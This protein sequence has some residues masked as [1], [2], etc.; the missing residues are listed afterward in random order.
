M[1][2]PYSSSENTGSTAN[3]V[4]FDSSVEAE[5]GV[6]SK[7]QEL[8]GETAIHP[9]VSV[10][11]EAAASQHSWN[12]EERLL[13][14]LVN[15][16]PESALLKQQFCF[17]GGS[18]E[19]SRSAL[20]LWVQNNPSS[21][22]S[23]WSPSLPQAEVERSEPHSFRASSSFARC[24]PG[25]D[26]N[27][28]LEYRDVQMRLL[29]E[30]QNY[31]HGLIPETGLSPE[32]HEAMILCLLSFPV[33]EFMSIKDNE[34]NELKTKNTSDGA[35]I[36]MLSYTRKAL[37]HL[38][39][40]MGPQ[41]GLVAL[42]LETNNQRDVEITA[43]LSGEECFSWEVWRNDFTAR[44]EEARKSQGAKGVETGPLISSN[45]SI[46]RGIVHAEVIAFGT[47]QEM[48]VWSG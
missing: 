12:Q 16:E 36:A 9:G 2:Y 18:M 15:D 4:Q 10:D 27:G 37:V 28:L 11:R 17:L 46:T 44:L 5:K 32:S 30:I 38:S 33:V 48:R 43:R 3:S 19:R 13:Y 29:W 8:R 23:V 35:S 1:K 25:N 21:P 45:E 26:W 40:P 39:V 47:G 41:P 20:A 6:C 14:L 42:R 34:E 24:L 7:N 31:F 22:E